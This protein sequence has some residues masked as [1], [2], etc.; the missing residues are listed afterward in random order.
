MVTAATKV[1][2]RVKPQA[3]ATNKWAKL[4]PC[5]DSLVIPLV[6]HRLLTHVFAS[7]S[8]AFA[9]PQDHSADVGNDD[10]AAFVDEVACSLVQGRRYHK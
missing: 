4:G 9:D 3:P 2:L 1:L 10:D 7:M 8:S 6:V 5:V